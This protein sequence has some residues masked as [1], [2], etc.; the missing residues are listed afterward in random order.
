MPNDL[1]TL[2]L[3][4]AAARELPESPIDLRPLEAADIDSLA[5]LYLAA[6]PPGVAAADLAEARTEMEESFAGDYGILRPDACATAWIEGEAV[7]AIIVVERSIWDEDLV[8]PFIID[9]FAS[10]A[11]RGHGVGTALVAHAVRA[12]AAAG[13]P[14]LS[15]RIGEG[16]SAAALHIYQRH[17]F[18]P[19][20]TS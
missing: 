4:G 11:A 14:A 13:A 12:C 8:G 5:A 18:T 1:L 9:L 16:T 2:P 6:Y 7:G 15:L 20:E 19:R 10:P 3:T 17:G